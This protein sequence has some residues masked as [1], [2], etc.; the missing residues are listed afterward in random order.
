[1]GLFAPPAPYLARRLGT[2]IGIA[3]CVAGIAAF[4]L[5]RAAVPGTLLVVLLTVPI[6]IAMG[7]AGTLL[8]M[9][10]KERFSD[11]AVV[12]TGVYVIAAAAPLALGAVRDA[13]GSFDTALWLLAGIS[14]ALVVS[15][16]PFSR[17]RLARGMVPAAQ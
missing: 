6:G 3:A 14:A 10:V 16:L 12:A 2:R 13:T 11:R 8:P 17:R 9:A 5:A 4:G 15:C 7:V 1:M